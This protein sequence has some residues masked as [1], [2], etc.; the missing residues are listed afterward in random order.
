MSAKGYI[1]CYTGTGKGKTTSALGLSLRAAGH[2]KR[3]LIIQFM[4]GNIDYGELKGVELL[5]PY[6]TLKQFGRAEFVSKENPENIDIE[7]AKK[8]FQYAKSC[9]VSGDWDIIILDEIN[10][11]LDFKLID[12]EEVLEIL[13]VKPENLEI[14]LTG[15]DAPP[16]IINIA[17]LVTEMREVKHYYT[18]GVMGRK[19]IE[20]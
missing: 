16:E 19:G 18:S 3:V 10:V 13:R 2:K 6:V 1:H 8:G 17:D 14:I 11:A 9:I 7:F 15:R 5:A 20:Y 4:K 12:I